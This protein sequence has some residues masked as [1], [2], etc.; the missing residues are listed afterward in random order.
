[1]VLLTPPPH[2]RRLSSDPVSLR[3]GSVG[4]GLLASL[5]SREGVLGRGEIGLGPQR[6]LQMFYRFRYPAQLHQ[7]NPQVVVRLGV[8][9]VDPERL[10]PMSHRLLWP[11]QLNQSDPQVVV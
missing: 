10:F 7:S 9:G 5:Q 2:T 8:I 6:L 1:M 4:L 11:A 3:F